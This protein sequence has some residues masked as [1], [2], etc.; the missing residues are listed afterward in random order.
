MK[1]FCPSWRVNAAT[2]FI[3][4]TVC[5]VR[6]NINQ[7]IVN[8]ES[9]QQGCITVALLNYTAIKNEGNVQSRC[10]TSWNRKIFM[11]LSLSKK[12][13][14]IKQ[15][16]HFAGSICKYQLN[17]IKNLTCFSSTTRVI[18]K[19]A[20]CIQTCPKSCEDLLNQNK[21]NIFKTREA[22]QPARCHLLVLIKEIKMVASQFAQEIELIF[23]RKQRIF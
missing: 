3:Y 8:T 4:L 19:V 18:E 2:N 13:D 11:Q 15:H 10:R 9:G 23:N 21:V 6:K 12:F 17:V 7:D 14:E 1:P 22:V 20:A 16:L 5:K